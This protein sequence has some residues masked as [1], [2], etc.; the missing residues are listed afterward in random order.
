MQSEQTEEANNY[1]YHRHSARKNIIYFR[2]SDKRCPAKLHYNILTKEITLKNQHLNPSEHKIPR[3]KQSKTMDQIINQP[4]E[5]ISHTNH[6]DYDLECHERFE[7]PRKRN[8]NEPLINGHQ[9]ALIKFSTNEENK[10]EEFQHI[11]SRKRIIK[12]MH[13]LAE[14][15]KTT[16][17]I[18]EIECLA[19]DRIKVQKIITQFFKDSTLK[20]YKQIFDNL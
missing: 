17:R 16:E 8:K 15:G 14:I 10:C 2:C 9:M 12:N 11:I 1:N 6:T 4:Q 20:T 13:I 5:I 3:S 18:I 7:L 19:E